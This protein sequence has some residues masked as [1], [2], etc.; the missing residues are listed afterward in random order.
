M[1]TLTTRTIK[2]TKYPKE[3]PKE[4][5]RDLKSA[6][7]AAP[8]PHVRIWTDGACK[9]NPGRGGWGALLR[10][11]DAA[12]AEVE[13]SGGETRTT[14]NRMELQACIEALEHVS[15]RQLQ[16][17]TGSAPWCCEL[18]TDSN[19]VKQGITEWIQKWRRN[20]WMTAKRKPVEN[21]ELWVKLYE[22]TQELQVQWKWVKGHSGHPENERADRLANAGVPPEGVLEGES[23]SETVIVRHGK[24]VSRQ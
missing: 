3:A 7:K 8:V 23:H 15:R 14:N 18:T 17:E 19:Y 5:L 16:L 20:G 2:S 24:L 6:T 12:G 1:T 10:Y 9:G 21:K 13:L 4:A 22:L 11:A